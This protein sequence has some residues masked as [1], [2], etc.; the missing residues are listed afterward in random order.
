[1]PEKTD[2]L[3][4]NHIND[5]CSQIGVYIEKVDKDKFTINKLVQDGVIRQLEIIGEAAR[6]IS[7]KTREAYK[8]IDWGNITGMRDKLIHD[9]TGVDLEIV[10]KT[11]KEDV[12][13]L[14]KQIEDLL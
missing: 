12:P 9:Y 3:Y 10:W 7:T 5:A 2:Y 8:E 1:M 13:E 4:L 11:V 14:K 6:K